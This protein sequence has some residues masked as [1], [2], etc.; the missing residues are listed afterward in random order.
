LGD[1][2][3]R[4]KVGLELYLAAGRAF[5]AELAR[6]DKRVFLDLKLHDIPETV[7]RAAAVAARQGVE[8][9]TVHASGGKAMLEAAVAGAGD[10]QILA[11]TVLTSLDLADLHADGSA[12]ASA[13]ELV[14]RRA[15]LAQAAG[16]AGVVASPLE[17]RAV[18]QAIGPRLL[19]VTPGVR[20]AVEDGPQSHDQKRVATPSAAREAGADAVVVGRPIRDAADA[21]QAVEQL[22]RE[23]A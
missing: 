14:V 16:C 8:L 2:V 3:Q 6:R 19:V 9:L 15:L 23:L 12:A 18:R 1:L 20:F 4:Y 17:A 11:V 5:V 22:L 13:E 7:H 10:T 21:R